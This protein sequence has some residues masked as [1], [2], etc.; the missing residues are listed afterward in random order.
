L[1]I[2]LAGQ[3]GVSSGISGGGPG[4]VTGQP[5]HWQDG[6]TGVNCGSQPFDS[7][8]FVAR[9]LADQNLNIN[10]TNTFAVSFP[11]TQY[12]YGSAYEGEIIQGLV[13]WL[14]SKASPRTCNK[15]LLL[16]MV[17]AAVWPWA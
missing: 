4:N 3:N 17:V 9:L 2:A 10:T 5:N 7:K 13:N 11:D 1:L 6:C 14:S 8:S 12:D 16:G 15:L